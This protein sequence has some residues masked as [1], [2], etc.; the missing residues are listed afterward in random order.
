[1][2]IKQFLLQLRQRQVRLPS[3]PGAQ[4]FSHLR[5][6]FTARPTRPSGWLL[7]FP[8]P[9]QADPYLLRPTRTDTKPRRQLLQAPF[10]F[11]VSLQQFASQIIRICFR[12]HFPQANC[13][14]SYIIA[15]NA[16][17]HQGWKLAD[18]VIVRKQ[19]LSLSMQPI[20]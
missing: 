15:E 19:D 16:L 12:H 13:Q 20:G 6:Q 9:L 8:R 14:S 4:L 7:H 5:R 17:D 2:P 10:A 11:L 1:M 18:S 3:N